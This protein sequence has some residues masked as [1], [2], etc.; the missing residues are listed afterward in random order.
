MRQRGRLCGCVT[1]RVLAATRAAAP[2]SRQLTRQW[3]GIPAR[4]IMPGRIPLGLWRE[5]AERHRWCQWGAPACELHELR[6]HEAVMPG[7]LRVSVRLVLCL[8]ARLTPRRCASP[9]GPPS[10]V[11]AGNTFEIRE[12]NA[13]TGVGRSVPCFATAAACRTGAFTHVLHAT[14]IMLGGGSE[15]GGLP[16]AHHISSMV[17]RAVPAA[18]ARL[19]R[20]W[21]LRPRHVCQ[22][23]EPW[24]MRKP[25]YSGVSFSFSSRVG[26][27]RC[28]RLPRFN[29]LVA[30]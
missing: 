1:R 16:R 20:W 18:G 8:C 17:C 5:G 2:R 23:T 10:R 27:L 7:V 22:G 12:D 19:S 30:S 9:G 3:M 15:L 14:T 4:T 28:F 11:W 6:V 21:G 25:T 29:G 24:H 26:V 13:E